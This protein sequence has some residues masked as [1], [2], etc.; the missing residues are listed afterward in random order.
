MDVRDKGIYEM[1][2][3]SYIRLEILSEGF[4]IDFTKVRRWKCKPKFV[5]LDVVRFKKS[6]SKAV[7]LIVSR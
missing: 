1:S 3:I 5:N 6:V 2:Y 4:L 7:I